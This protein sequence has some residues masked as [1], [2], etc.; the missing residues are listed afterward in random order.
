MGGAPVLPPALRP[1]H[2]RP[3]GAALFLD[4]DGTLAPIVADPSVARPL[5]G[6]VEV[7]GHLATRLAL[8]AVVS[9]RPAEFLATALG[10]PPGLRLLGLYGLEEVGADGRVRSPASVEQWRPVVARVTERARATAPGGLSIE[11]KGLTVTL[12]WRQHPGTAGWAEAFADDQCARTGLVAQRGRMAVELR[13]PVAVDKGTAVRALAEGYAA[14][15]CF[16]DDLG[17]LAAF[18]ALGQLASQGIAVARVAVTDAESPPEVAAAADVVVEGP[19]GALAL[20]RLLG[21]EG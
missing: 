5:D 2:D 11:A 14:V 6:V 19:A 3:G 4:F 17:D 1:L 18:A 8:V 7:L 16:G 21:D 13:P 12:H 9:G 15:G 20:L 10:P